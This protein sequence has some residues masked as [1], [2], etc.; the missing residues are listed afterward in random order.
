MPDGNSE[1]QVIFLKSFDTQESTNLFSDVP[2][3]F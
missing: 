1:Y 3:V 2:T